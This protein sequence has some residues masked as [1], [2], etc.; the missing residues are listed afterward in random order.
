MVAPR[1]SQDVDLLSAQ[2]GT[3]FLLLAPGLIVGV[4][5]Y[6]GVKLSSRGWVQ[7]GAARQIAMLSEV[8]VEVIS[9]AGVQAG[10][11]SFPFVKSE[12]DGDA[13]AVQTGGRAG[14]R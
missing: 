7:A 4:P 10:V 14:W 12:A 3:H 9:Q 1:S 5:S 8:E 13:A 2:A 6:V 11:L